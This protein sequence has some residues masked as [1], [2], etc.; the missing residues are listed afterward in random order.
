MT[1]LVELSDVRKLYDGG[2]KHPALNGVSLGVERG[3]FLA[4]MAPPGAESRPSSTWWPGSTG[5]LP[6][7]C[8]STAATSAAPVRQSWPGTAGA[9]WGSCSSSS[10][11]LA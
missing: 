8:S 1:R 4:V 11:C 10:T 5:R 9:G 7:E 6:A 2:A 3:E